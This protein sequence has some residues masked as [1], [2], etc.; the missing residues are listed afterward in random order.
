METTDDRGRVRLLAP[1]E[2]RALS[3]RSDLRGF[4]HLA[5]HL[6][7]IAGGAALVWAARGT[8]WVVLA[9]LPLGWF[10]VALFAPV[11][12]CVHYTAFR[13]RRLNDWVGWAAAVPS[14]LNFDFY[15]HF[16]YAHHRYCQDP[17]R[18]PELAPPA[19]AS[20]G[21]YLLRL[22]AFN[23]WRSRF[24]GA[25]RVQRGDFDAFAFVPERARPEVRR[26]VAA[27]LA[28][29]AVVALGWAAIDPWGP[30]LYWIGPVVLAQ[31]ILRGIL[32]AEHTLCEESG[33]TLANTRTTL[34][35][36]PVRLLHWNMPYHTEHHLYPS[37]PFHALPAAH[38]RLRPHL[39]HVADGYAPTHRAIIGGL[40][41]R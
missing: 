25:L 35:A 39:V 6:A 23:Y 18:D 10:L 7:L 15:K 34:A 2:V 22:T 4:L 17:V 37:I 21:Q 5:L 12:E 16:H 20:L 41:T 24:V 14:L 40:A 3:V 8:G 30:V 26:S 13:T 38:A 32:L 19:P 9:M 11:H 33:D 29:A 31:P 36:W 27:M 1:A 28:L